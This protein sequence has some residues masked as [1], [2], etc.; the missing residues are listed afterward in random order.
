M[1]FTPATT[2]RGSATTARVLFG[3]TMVAPPSRCALF[4]VGAYLGRDM[5]YHWGWVWFIAGIGCLIGM[6]VAIP[7]RSSWRSSCSSPSGW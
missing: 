6:N 5:S 7:A 1:S 2:A 3:Q 4:A